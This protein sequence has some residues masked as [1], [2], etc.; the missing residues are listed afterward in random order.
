MV[1][2]DAD[3]AGALASSEPPSIGA[4]A[5]TGSIAAPVVA[6]AA[7]LAGSEWAA[8]AFAQPLG[9]GPEDL[10]ARTR[11]APL[12]RSGAQSVRAGAAPAGELG[13][14]PPVPAHDPREDEADERVA[15]ES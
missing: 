11:D 5:A 13:G 12:D 15:A 3:D 1:P 14:A 7:G 8:A 2:V 6:G 9:L 10:L 4:L